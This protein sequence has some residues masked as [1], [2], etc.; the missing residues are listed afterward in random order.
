MQWLKH[1]HQWCN[2]GSDKACSTARHGCY[3]TPIACT[4]FCKY[5]GTLSCW[6]SFTDN[7]GAVSDDYDDSNETDDEATDNN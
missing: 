6:N 2:C 7:T 3:W 1:L 4:L 5:K